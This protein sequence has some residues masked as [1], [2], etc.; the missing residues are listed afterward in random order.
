MSRLTTAAIESA[1]TGRLG[2]PCRFFEEIDSTNAEALRWAAEGAPEGSLV[3]ADYQTAGRGRMG[4]RWLSGPGDSLL[5]SVILRPEGSGRHSLLTTA[6]GVACT[7][8]IRVRTEVEAGLKWPNDVM[9]G[10]RKVAGILV[11]GRLSGNGI[12]TAVAG[13]GINC[14][15]STQPP[16]EIAQ[17]AT[18]IANET[19]TSPDSLSLLIDF[20]ARFERLYERLNHP[21]AASHVVNRA[22]DLSVVLGRSVSVR[23]SNGRLVEGLAERLTHDGGLMI[24]SG[25]DLVEARAGEIE[26]LR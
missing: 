6:L 12:E 11:E 4:R 10:G 20:L 23:F 22:T 15:F 1:V 18:S 16:D 13:V 8:T 7:E 25:I 21:A 26:Q 3:A 14:R 9:I 2:R 19:G 5:F 24:R 17:T